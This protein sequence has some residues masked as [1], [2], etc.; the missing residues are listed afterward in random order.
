MQKI[1]FYLNHS[2]E[3]FNSMKI[4]LLSDFSFRSLILIQPLITISISTLESPPLLL[5]M[6]CQG[7]IARVSTSIMAPLKYLKPG[8]PG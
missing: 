6:I 1:S 8:K 3:F 2:A 5:L 7:M 4:S